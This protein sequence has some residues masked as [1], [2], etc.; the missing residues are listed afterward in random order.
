MIP[1]PLPRWLAAAALTTALLA[2]GALLDG[3]PTELDAARDQEAAL[4]DALAQAQRERPDLWTP[5]TIA[6][7]R[8]AARV[9]AY[10]GQP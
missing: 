10:G 4:L 3:Q 2:T 9:A 5:E 7:A 8:T 6:R 1:L